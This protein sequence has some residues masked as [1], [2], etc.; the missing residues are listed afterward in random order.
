[1]NDDLDR[2]FASTQLG[3]GEHVDILDAYRMFAKDKGWYKK[4]EDNVK[5]GLTAEA[6]VERS[7]EDMWNRLSGTNDQYLKERLHDLRDVADRMQSY[8]SGDFKDIGEIRNWSDIVVVAQTM[9]PADLM[10]YDYHKIRGL[11]IEDGTPTMHVAIVAKALNIPV[12]AK[13]KG[14]FE[15][16][17]TGELIAVDGNDSYVYI[18]PQPAVQEKFK[19][20][21]AEKEKLLARLAELRKLPSKRRT[22]SVSATTSTSVFPLIS[23]ISKAPT[24]TALGCIEPKSRLWLPMLCRMSNGSWGIIRNLWTGPETGRLFSAV[25]TLVRTSSCLIGAIWGRKIRLSA[26]ARFAFRW[27]AAPFCASR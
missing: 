12:I 20:K 16:V 4:I 18:N 1:M 2:K 11:I 25:W 27:I 8:L 13:I 5:S 21:I 6:A 9:G 15:E 14:L 3:I 10:D 19:A 17:K 26:G 23:T 24:V 22:A 7:Y